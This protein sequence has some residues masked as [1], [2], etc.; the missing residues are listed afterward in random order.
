MVL[1]ASK[2]SAKSTKKS[3]MLLIGALFIG[4]IITISLY[5]SFAQLPLD[6]KAVYIHIP[7]LVTLFSCLVASLITVLRVG[8][9][10]SEGRYYLSLVIAMGLW[11]CAQSIWA[12]SE[13]LQIFTYPSIADFFWLLGFVFLGYHFYHSFK[14]WKQA[15]VIKLYSVIGGIIIT[16]ILIGPLIYLSLQSST[17][18]DLAS[19]I[20]S[21]LYVVSNGILLTPA[22]VIMWSL[23][24]RDI[25]LLHRILIC[26]FLILNM[27]GDVTY[28]Y[29]QILVGE[30]VVAEQEWIWGTVY[31]ISFLMLI[32]GLI[33]Y[34]KISTTLNKNI[35]I[36][37][38]R[39]YPYLEKLWNE[40]TDNYN[41]TSN[42]SESDEGLVEH[43]TNPEIINNKIEDTIRKTNEKI[44]ILI[45][46]KDV[47]LKIKTQI[48][49]FIE[50]FSELNVDVRILIPGSDGLQD[51]AIE[52]EKHSNFKFQRLYNPL[53]KDNAIFVIDSNAILDLEFKKDEDILNGEKELLLYSEREA[54]V[55]SYLALFENCW[56]LPSVHEKRFSRQK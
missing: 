7:A 11:F 2:T 26:N 20:V 50:I 15:K 49:K 22:I 17:D 36:T 43:L 6:E 51:L 8:L 9:K 4:I 27:L 35:E 40:P 37:I 46:T 31:T 44:L 54:Q 3:S 21:N 47:F 48:Y 53:T 42:M 19:T 25:F 32:A 56:I 18:T 45:S 12:H 30:D 24:G 23:V 38:D 52:L 14:F 41:H 33:W 16:S 55:Q 13:I 28:V 10:S 5:F 39:L 29:Y 1:A 34:N